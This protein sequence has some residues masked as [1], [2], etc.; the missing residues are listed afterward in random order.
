MPL[1]KI[2]N[3]FKGS[4]YF[5]QV[6]TLASGTAFAQII[7]VLSYLFLARIYDPG[8]FG[9]FKFF[10]STALILSIIGTLAFEHAIVLPQRKEVALRIFKISIVFLIIWGIFCAIT[11]WLFSNF[12]ASNFEIKPILLLFTVVGLTVIGLVNTFGNWFI[13]QNKFRSLSIARILQA[14]TTSFFQIIWGL[15]KLGS[16]GLIIGYLFGRIFSTVYYFLKSGIPFRDFLSTKSRE[17]I[18][19]AKNFK[20]QPQYVF[21]SKL[22]QQLA[23]EIPIILTSLLFNNL[24]LGFLAL[25]LKALASPTQ[26]LGSSVGQ[27]FYKHISDRFNNKEPFLKLLINTWK[28]LLLVGIIPFTSLLIWGKFIFGFIFG[29]EWIEAGQIAS[30]LAP[31]IFAYFIIGP[32]ER[33]TFLVLGLQNKILIFSILDVIGKSIGMLI[34]F[35]ENDYLL[36]IK[37]ISGFQLITLII[38]AVYILVKVRLHSSKLKVSMD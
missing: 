3:K 25:A 31:A 23:Q 2:L 35:L 14:S 20:E 6:F 29:N 30:I 21:P 34:G 32:T 9:D 36:S 5:K 7:T 24:L 37:L 17:L 1:L 8:E 19:T 27:V 11:F 26:F 15:N 12:L 18:Q 33:A 4:E 28:G 10:E 22:V 38:M 13:Q 16:F